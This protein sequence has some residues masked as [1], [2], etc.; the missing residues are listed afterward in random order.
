MEK[1]KTLRTS[2]WKTFMFLIGSLL[3]VVSSIMLNEQNDI[4]GWIGTFF[5]GLCAIVFI[6]QL[7]PNSSYLKLTKE[8]FEEKNLF[9][10]KFTNWNE[11]DSFRVGYITTQYSRQKKIMFDY[12]NSYEKAKLMRKLSKS[13]AGNEGSLVDNYGMKVEELINLLNEWKNESK[14]LHNNK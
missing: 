2:K 8:G 1:T 10:T 6:I 11:I 9:K 5:F 3:F 7:L 4:E 13:L 14:T 12:S